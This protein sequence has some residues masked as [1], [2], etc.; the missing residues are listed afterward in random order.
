MS[1]ELGKRE[2]VKAKA[3]TGQSE[4]RYGGWQL[5]GSGPAAGA[6]SYPSCRF[7]LDL[8]LPVCRGSDQL[9]TAPDGLRRGGSGKGSATSRR[10]PGRGRGHFHR[11]R[12]DSPDSGGAGAP[13][14]SQL[15]AVTLCRSA[16]SN[17]SDRV[18]VWTEF[19]PAE[20]ADR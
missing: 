11:A 5:T 16:A 10:L 6:G 1:G 9:R 13:R 14:A 15:W 2:G 20:T 19:H 8:S 18:S 4:P 12:P 17:T 7:T 3:R